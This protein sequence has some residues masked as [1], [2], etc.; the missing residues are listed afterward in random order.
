MKKI[1]ALV[2]TVGMILGLAA[3]PGMA[4]DKTVVIKI[5]GDRVLRRDGVDL[6]EAFERGAQRALELALRHGC[7][8]AVVK[9]RSPSCGAGRIYDGTFSGQLC[10]GDG[11][12]VRLLRRHGV[13]EGTEEDVAEAARA[14]E[15][16][17][18]DS[19]RS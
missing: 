4:A 11:L 10:D 19:N 17:N 1:L 14:A 13:E 16:T 15:R 8:R 7:R 12:W 3:A 2:L 6:T 5:A 9:S 18:A